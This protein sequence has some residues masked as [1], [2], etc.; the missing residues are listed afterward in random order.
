MGAFV[1]A[2]EISSLDVARQI[3]NSV[4]NRPEH[5]KAPLQDKQQTPRGIKSWN[6]RTP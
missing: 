2:P 5:Q 1:V 6:T 3:S 4:R